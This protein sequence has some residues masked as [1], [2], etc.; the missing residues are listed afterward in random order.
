MYSVGVIRFVSV[1][2]GGVTSGGGDWPHPVRNRERGGGRQVVGCR[3][4]RKRSLSPH[5]VF[6]KNI[7]FSISPHFLNLSFGKYEAE[8]I[9]FNGAE[10]FQSC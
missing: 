8:E 9:L 10:G 6:V 2:S 3:V 5:L 4:G 1:T 7:S